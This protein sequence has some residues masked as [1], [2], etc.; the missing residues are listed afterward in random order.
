[1]RRPSVHAIEDLEANLDAVTDM[2][3]PGA[4]LPLRVGLDSRRE[5]TAV[6]KAARAVSR[7]AAF[8]DCDDVSASLRIVLLRYM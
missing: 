7:E 8:E 3:P 1:M 4:A 5:R 6:S 2:L